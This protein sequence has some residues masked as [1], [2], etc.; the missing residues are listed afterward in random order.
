MLLSV[1]PRTLRDLSR[2]AR[3]LAALALF[4]LGTHV[5]VFAPPPALAAPAKAAAGASEHGCCGAAKEQASRDAEATRR[6][7]A[8]CCVAVSPV[9]AAHGASVDPAPVLATPVTLGPLETPILAPA[10]ARLAL[11]EDSRPPD[12]CS[13]TPDAGRAPPRL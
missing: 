6:A 1:P 9:L 10:L 8:P 5:C 11:A 2:R 13:A 3:A 4:L 12:R 7:T